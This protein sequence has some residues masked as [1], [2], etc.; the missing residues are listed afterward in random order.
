M[1]ELNDYKFPEFNEDFEGMIPKSEGSGS[2]GGIGFAK[3]TFTFGKDQT[4]AAGQAATIVTSNG[5]TAEPMPEYDTKLADW[6]S[7]DEKPGLIIISTSYALH[8]SKAFTD[9]GYDTTV[10]NASA[11]SISVNTNTKIDY[12]L[13]YQKQ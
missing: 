5:Y 8:P 2:S 9:E 7:C 6:F 3:K 11:Q 13:L 4:I 10:F 1:H 12:N